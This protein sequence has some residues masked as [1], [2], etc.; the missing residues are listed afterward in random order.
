[1]C[2]SASIYADSTAFTATGAVCGHGHGSAE[3][4]SRR[5]KKY[6]LNNWPWPH[7]GSGNAEIISPSTTP[8]HFPGEHCGCSGGIAG[9]QAGIRVWW[10][11]FSIH[12]VFFTR[13]APERPALLLSN[14]VLFSFFATSDFAAPC[15]FAR[16]GIS[17]WACRGNRDR[18]AHR[19]SGSGKGAAG[20][21]GECEARHVK[22]HPPPRGRARN[23]IGR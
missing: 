7:S 14:R 10:M 1:M 3:L 16:F 19:P 2:F 8:K 18:K 15:A 22:G 6:S 11:N 5:S 23:S 17:P 21:R 20:R 4:R 13:P 12:F 9:G